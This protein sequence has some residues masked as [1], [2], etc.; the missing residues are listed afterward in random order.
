MSSIYCTRADIEDL[1]GV[2]NVE[3]WADLDNDLDQDN[4]DDRITRAI[5]EASDDIDEVMRGGPYDIPIVVTGGST[6]PT[7]IT[8]I[9]ATLAGVWLYTKRGIE[10]FDQE[11][12]TAKHKL[13]FNEDEARA[14]LAE[15][16]AS[17]RRLDAE[18]I[19]T[20]TPHSVDAYTEVSEDTTLTSDIR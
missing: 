7:G 16:R 11:E 1:F 3:K 18:R 13:A 14:K 5:T 6:T 19:G 9:A 10:D 8:N 4:I 20:M 2:S 17:V 12:G 15:Y